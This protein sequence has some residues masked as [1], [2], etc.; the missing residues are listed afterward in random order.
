MNVWCVLLK[1]LTLNT[2]LFPFDGALYE[3]FFLFSLF[4]DLNKK[5]VSQSHYDFIRTTSNVFRH[6]HFIGNKVYTQPTTQSW[7]RGAKIVFFM[8]LSL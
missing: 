3:F 5:T 2:N 7:R 4:Y 8:W 6:Q 1:R